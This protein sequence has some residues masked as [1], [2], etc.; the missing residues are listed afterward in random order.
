MSLGDVIKQNR[1]EKNLTAAELASLVD[2]TQ[3]YLSKIENGKNKP[4]NE[5]IC[6]LA[7][8]LELEERYLRFLNGEYTETE[9]KRLKFVDNITRHK[10]LDNNP[11]DN[12]KHGPYL[13]VYQ[14]YKYAKFEDFFNRNFLVEYERNLYVDEKKLTQKE[15]KLLYEVAKTFVQDRDKTYPSP[16]EITKEYSALFEKNKNTEITERNKFYLFPPD[17]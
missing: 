5:V 10:I 6:K 14:N 1:K 13:Y 2:I 11:L 17:E 15:L 7:E 3:S 9:Y 16:I 8:V 4:S 12:S